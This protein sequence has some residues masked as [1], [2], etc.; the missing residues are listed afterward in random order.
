ME[1][2][3]SLGE[4]L[5]PIMDSTCPT[6][7]WQEWNP[8]IVEAYVHHDVEPKVIKDRTLK[9]TV[10]QMQDVMKQFDVYYELSQILMLAN[11]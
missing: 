6:H 8:T 10:S 9:D 11:Y 1:A 4:A 5:H 7:N 2:Y 3:M